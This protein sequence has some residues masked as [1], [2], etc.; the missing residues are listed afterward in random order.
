[1]NT[2]YDY[3]SLTDHELMRILSTGDE[4]SFYELV[5]RYQQNMVDYITRLVGNA[6]RAEELA[7]DVFIRVF[8]HRF[9]YTTD[10]SFATWC[11]KIATNIARD[12]YRANSRRITKPLAEHLDAVASPEKGPEE[13]A[14]SKEDA[15]RVSS[16]LEQMPEHLREV[17]VMR[18]LQACS[19][20]E[21]AATLDL[22][23]GTV[24]SRINRARL[25]FKE[26]YMSRIG[27]FDT[28]VSP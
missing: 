2:F 20:Q 21:I 17:L 28:R 7:Q 6:A 23:L 19:Y 11:Y 4:K 22:E 10:A 18:D 25:A 24:K 27:P 3:K 16:I 9:D 1:M 14:S 8:R 5:S 12:E 13:M 15:A 26:A